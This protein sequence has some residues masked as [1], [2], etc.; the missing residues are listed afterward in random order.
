MK[1]SDFEALTF[2]C[3]GTLIQWDEGII[4]AMELTLKR[5]SRSDVSIS[6]ILESYD[7][8]ELES[9]QT[10]PSRNFRAIISESLHG[11]FGEFGDAGAHP[12]TAAL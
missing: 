3:Y 4:A 11:A 1:L 9:E 5:L 7:R 8:R 2:D 6:D 12:Q 10:P